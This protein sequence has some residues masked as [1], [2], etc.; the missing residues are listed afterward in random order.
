MLGELP[1][2]NRITG[3]ADKAH[4]YSFCFTQWGQ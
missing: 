1:G 3:G 4:A 2:K